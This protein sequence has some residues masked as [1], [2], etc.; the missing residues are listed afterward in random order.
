MAYVQ[1][2]TCRINVKAHFELEINLCC[3]NDISAVYLVINKSG[4][5]P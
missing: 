1:A 2:E 4:W 5:L 3:V